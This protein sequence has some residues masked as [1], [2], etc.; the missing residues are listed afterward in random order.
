MADEDK[1]LFIYT[2]FP[3][4]AEARELGEH[5]VKARLAACVNMFPEIV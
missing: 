4:E 5:L 1:A 3:S 2:T